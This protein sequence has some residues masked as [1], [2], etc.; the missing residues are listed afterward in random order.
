[1]P[2]HPGAAGVAQQRPAGAAGDSAADR[3]ADGGGQ[4]HEDHLGALADDTEDAVAVLVTQIGDVR[5]AGLED[6]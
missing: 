3:A 2:V 5:G 1:V 4:G 6:A